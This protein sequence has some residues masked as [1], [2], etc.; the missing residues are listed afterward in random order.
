MNQFREYLKIFAKNLFVLFLLLLFLEFALFVMGFSP[1]ILSKRKYLKMVEQISLFEGYK[2]DEAGIT[3]IS[4][5]AENYL[6]NYIRNGKE[7]PLWMESL[8]LKHNKRNK[9]PYIIGRDYVDIAD[10][11]IG[12][13]FAVF[14][15]QLK[16]KDKPDETDIA[17]LNYVKHPVN[18]DGFRSIDF[19]NFHTDKKKILLLGDSFTWGH[20]TKNKTDSF[21]DVL[22][23]RGFIV[24]NSGITG[25]DIPQYYAVAKKYLCR[26][27]PDY[28]IVN[29][30]LGND[31]A[32]F[33]RKPLPY[34]PV[35]F[36]TNAGLLYSCPHGKYFTDAQT[37]YDFIIKESSIPHQDDNLLNFLFAQTRITTILWRGLSAKGIV[38]NSADEAVSAY[39]KEVSSL[40][41]GYSINREYL[42][43]I[44]QL[45]EDVNACM[46]VSV[47][48]EMNNI[49]VPASEISKKLDTFE[50]RKIDNLTQSDYFGRNEHFSEQ[51]H[52]KYAAYLI[53]LMEENSCT[54][55]KENSL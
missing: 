13:E 47:I 4:A 32:E 7:L 3:S 33:D 12:N 44:R 34:T 49:A 22:S 17:Y 36:T 46:I 27:M 50:F 19:K 25:A 35:F 8:Q 1:G 45:C 51:G 14:I 26:V 23:A 20:H 29:V 38:D 42:E 18:E 9:T 10:N 52:R 2:S 43:Q 41:K 55:N 40:R 31:I 5:D 30:F 16:K 53:H 11:R 21:A 54:S 39:W 28:V 24:Y 6:E 37:A 15:Q 48:P